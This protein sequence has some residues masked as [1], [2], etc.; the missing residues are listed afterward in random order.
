M[1][2]SRRSPPD[3]GTPIRHDLTWRDEAFTDPAALDREMR[4]VFDICHGC[5]RCFNLCDSFPRLFDL[6]DE[7]ATGELDS[8]DSASFAPVVDACTLCDMCFMTK[9]PYVPPHEF[10]LD[11]PHLMLRAK[12]AKRAR[13]GVSFAERQLRRTDRN[14]R[15]G[16]ALAGAANWA[17]KEANRTVRRALEAVAGVHRKAR[18]PTFAGQTLVRRAAREAPEPNR[19]APAWG[20]R[21]VLYATCHGNYNKP[22]VGLA[23]RA[24]LARNGVETAVVHPACCGMPQLEIGDLAAVAR[25]ATRVAS[26]FTEWIDRG[27]AVVALTS[28][29]ALML[30]SEWPRIVPDD[31]NVRR[32]AAATRD[33]AEYVVDN[34]PH[35]GH[36]RRAGAAVRAGGAAPRLPRARAERGRESCRAAP[37]HPRHRGDRDRAL[38]GPR[39]RMGRGDGALRHGAQG[40]P[41]GRAPRPEGAAGVGR[42]R[43]PPGGRPYRPGH[44]DARSR[45]RGRPGGASDRTAGA[46]LRT[47]GRAVTEW[48]AH[49]RRRTLTRADILSPED[50]AAVRD[51]ARARVRAAQRNRRVYVGPFA[52]FLFENF[53]TLWLQ[54]HEM[55]RIEQ[56]G[57][58]QI[59]D[60]LA[61]YGP[62]V[63]GGRELV[64]TL[65][66]QID[67]RARRARVLSTLGGVE[68]TV[69]F[70]VGGGEIAAEPEDDQPR[71][72]PEGR[73]SSVHFLRFRFPAPRIAAFRDPGTDVGLEI[74]HP[75]AIAMPPRFPRRCA[76]RWPTTSTT[77]DSDSARGLVGVDAPHH[78]PGQ[79]ATMVAELDPAPIAAALAQPAQ[80]TGLHPRDRYRAATEGARRSVRTPPTTSTIRAPVSRLRCTHPS[81]PSKSR[82]RRQCSCSATISTG[83]P[84]PDEHPQDGVLGTGTDAHVDLVGA[85]SREAR[86]RQLLG[87]GKDGNERHGCAEPAREDAPPRHGG[88]CRAAPV[89]RQAAGS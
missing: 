26:A 49:P 70:R 57:A 7:S 21:A 79:P 17:M 44:G 65:M 37:P 6:I 53:D 35:R 51:E 87:G 46:R 73:T 24:V 10:D 64:A 55:L 45:P 39:R 63:P 30:K 41:P 71:S 62:L 16:S 20:R 8:V 84:D 78:C 23:A 9:C 68:E 58:A 2:G 76:P 59:A 15:L 1:A 42:L 60:E 34:R 11:F 5:R 12:A 29:C 14:G 85:Q 54:V 77:R 31:D 66:F 83:S 75:R 47:R 56:G 19:D 72:T 22:S 86:Q 25:S 61:A 81:A 3:C 69:R 36:R 50:Y 4:R 52:T 88:G 27:H 82:M 40:G 80:D 33:I 13:G 67:D 28:S 74:G 38:L 48:K 43:M 18:L 89:A 32:L